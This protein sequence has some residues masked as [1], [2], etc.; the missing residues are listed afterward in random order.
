[1][2]IQLVPLRRGKRYTSLD[3]MRLMDMK[4]G[5]FVVGLCTLESS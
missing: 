2:Q 4:T 1:L 3:A 5:A